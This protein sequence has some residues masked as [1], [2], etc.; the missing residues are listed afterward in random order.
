[1]KIL[2]A[3]HYFLPHKGGIEFV[4]YNQAKELVKQGHDVTIVSS[5]VGDEPEEEIM[6]GIKIRR[7]KAWNF[8][9]RKWGIPYPVFSLKLIK[10]LNKEIKEVDIVHVHDF[11]Y[12]PSFVG[13]LVS[14]IR[15][16]PF[17]MM[18]HVETIKHSKWIVNFIQWLVHKTYG[19]FI[20]NSAKKIIVCNEQVKDWLGE[21]EKTIFIENSVDINLFKPA[22]NQNKNKLRKKYNLPTN[23]PIIIFVG[24]LV[25]V[26]G[27][28]KLFE[29]RDKDY[30]I[31]FVGD[32]ETPEHMQNDKNAIF[33]GTLPQKELKEIYQLSD[34][35]ILPSKSEGFPLTVLEAMASGLPIIVSNL[36][37]YKRHLDVNNIHIINPTPTNI[38][39]SIKKLLGDKTKIAKMKK[40]SREE[41]I[42]KFSWKKNAKKL[43]NVYGKVL[44][45]NEIK[46]KK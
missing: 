28:D 42:N 14:K 15:K 16:K 46:S 43:L 21:Q 41:A 29:A 19:R 13:A 44:K 5:K 11:F 25:E 37:I 4:A 22:T 23:K 32:G 27:F 6:D 31:I 9:E 36:P 18:Q 20:I 35:F 33:M 34:V 39:Y 8:F 45:Q 3:T 1:M 30:T 17:V 24:R 10:V 7:V 40:Y 12:L 2:I 38:K 26:K